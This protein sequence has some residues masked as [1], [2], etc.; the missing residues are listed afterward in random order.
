MPGIESGH[1]GMKH[2]LRKRSGILTGPRFCAAIIV[3]GSDR[4]LIFLVLLHLRRDAT[5]RVPVT[6]P[7]ACGHR[8]FLCT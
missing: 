4:Y 8:F 3:T 5:I 1:G 6:L 7:E 2:R